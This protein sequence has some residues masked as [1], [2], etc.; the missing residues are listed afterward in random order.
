MTEKI[1]E[2]TMARL[3]A[4]TK[5]MSGFELAELD[6]Q[7]RGQGEIY[8]ARQSGM[9]ELKIADW[10]DIELIKNSRIV[11]ESMVK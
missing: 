2:K 5:S 3:T 10:N 8:G 1:T 7:M 11:A 4:M 9:P 6:L